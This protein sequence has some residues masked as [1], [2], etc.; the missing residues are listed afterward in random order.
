MAIKVVHVEDK[1]LQKKLEAELELL[2]TLKHKHI[3]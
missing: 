1:R 2:R 3:V